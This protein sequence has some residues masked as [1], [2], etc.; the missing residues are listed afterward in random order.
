MLAP[1]IAF[2]LIFA[3]LFTL[4]DGLQATASFAMRA[5]GMIWLPSAI[6][7]GSFFVVMLPLCFWLGI[8]LDRG[9]R[10]VI[11]G[12]GVALVVAGTLQVLLLEWKAARPVKERAAGSVFAAH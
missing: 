3:G 7:L 9:A 12:A 6:H 10:G 1:A 5:Q 4:F 8:T 2:L 11:E